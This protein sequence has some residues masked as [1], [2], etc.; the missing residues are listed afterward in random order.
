[1]NRHSTIGL[2]TAIFALYL[3]SGCASTVRLP[4]VTQAPD[5]FFPAFSRL[6]T[7][8][9]FIVPNSNLKPEWKALTAGSIENELHNAGYF[10]L[11]DVSHREDLL[12][13]LAFQASGITRESTQI[14]VW[15]E[16]DG[17]LFLEFFQPPVFCQRSDIFSG[18]QSFVFLRASLVDVKTSRRLSVTLSDPIS[19][20]ACGDKA[21]LLAQA[22]AQIAVKVADGVSPRVAQTPIP[23]SEDAGDVSSGETR[24]RVRQLLRSGVEWV[25]A[26]PPNFDYARRDW[27]RSDQESRGTSAGAAWNLAIASWHDRDYA[28]AEALFQRALS[29]QAASPAQKRIYG[30]FAEEKKR[31]ET[32]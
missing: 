10:N 14:G 29:G 28:K 25:T 21:A 24:S 8:G 9:L 16:T 20:S 12:S 2:L 32:R 27:E 11:V 7:I 18:Y 13:E 6:R 23:L 17:L 22:V 3:A 31:F 1:M 5:R 19:T 26:D 30:L 4:V 15:D